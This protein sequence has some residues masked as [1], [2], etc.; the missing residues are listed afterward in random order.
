L[1]FL[2]SQAFAMPDLPKGSDF[3]QRG[4]TEMDGAVALEP[5]NVGVLMP[6]GTA[7][8]G[9]S[10]HMPDPV[11]SNALLKTGVADYEKVLRLQKAHFTDLP[12]NAR[13]ELLFGL[14]D[15]WHRLQ[16]TSRARQYFQRVVDEC[17]GSAYAEQAK[18]WLEYKDP[19]TLPDSPA[20]SACI[21]C[22]GK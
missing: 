2:A 4:M 22:H 7:L 8:L 15:G 9:V 5:D 19:N 18:V 16:N 3:W 12:L 11:Q 13:G 1:I 21:G 14:A 17:A 20:T 6:R 10:K